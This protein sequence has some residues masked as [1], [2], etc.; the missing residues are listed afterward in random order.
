MTSL[1]RIFAL[2]WCC[3]NVLCTK[4]HHF[5]SKK[6]MARAG[7]SCHKW[8]DRRIDVLSNLLCN[9]RNLTCTL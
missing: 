7:N 9:E 4:H 8:G 1:T 2:L 3:H 5:D 6:C